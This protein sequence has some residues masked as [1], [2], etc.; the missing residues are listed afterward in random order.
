MKYNL[1]YRWKNNP[2]RAKCYGKRCRIMKRLAMNSALVEFEDGT[3]I[4]T[5]RNAIYKKGEM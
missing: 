2:V 5:S 3:K 1:I 4:I